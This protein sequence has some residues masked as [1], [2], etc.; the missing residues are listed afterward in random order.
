MDESHFYLGTYSY[1]SQE[2]GGGRGRGS[3]SLLANFIC[4]Q[5]TAPTPDIIDGTDL[6]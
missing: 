3:E 2:E 6:L 4:H 5:H 1:K